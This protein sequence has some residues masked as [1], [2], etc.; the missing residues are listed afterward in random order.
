[1]ARTKTLEQLRDEIY[2]RSDV[3]E[4]FIVDTEMNQMINGSIADLY[5]LLVNINKDF[6]LNSDIIPVVAG[7]DAYT[8]PPD[9]WRSVGVDVS[10]GNINYSM[11]RF[12]FA[13]RNMYQTASAGKAITRYRIMG[14]NIRFSP[15]PNWSGNVTLWYIPTAEILVNNTDTFDGIVGWEEY[16]I[17]DC[18]IKIRSKR[19]EDASVE[20]AQKKLLYSRI[21][22]S[23]NERDDGE[24]DRVRD[25]YNEMNGSDWSGLY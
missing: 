20:M 6:Y 13:E 3:S 12:N 1:M 18:V 24:P 17:V 11:R 22:N 4:N 8:L 25:I 9:F 2:K 19:E 14:E 7:T 21:M 23:A 10:E 5:D 16:V 15:V